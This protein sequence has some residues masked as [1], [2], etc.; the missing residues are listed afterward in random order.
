LWPLDL[1]YHRGGY[2]Y[3]MKLRTS[4][5]SSI[6][7]LILG[8]VKFGKAGPLRALTTAALGIIDCFRRLHLSG[9]CYKDINYGGPFFRP[10]TGDVLICDNDNVRPNR[11]RGMIFF[12][13]FAAPEVN[14]GEADCTTETDTHSLAVLLYYIFVRGNPFEGRREVETVVFEENAKLRTFGVEPIFVFDPARESNRPVPGIHD[15]V[16]ANWKRLPGY[17][18]DTFAQAFVA[19]VADPRKRPNDTQWLN[20]ISRMRDALCTCPHCRLEAV[21]PF[22]SVGANQDV[23]CPFCRKTAPAQPRIRFKSSELWL[24][25]GCQLFQHHL[26]VGQHSSNV[27]GQ[28]TRH[29]TK[30]DLA[31]IRNMTAQTWSFV[32]KDGAPK[33]VPPGKSAAVSPGRVINFGAA[34][35]TIAS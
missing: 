25:D 2:G 1:V 28:F 33:E 19:G 30:R 34:T 15:A 20:A 11:T 16:I 26:G 24:S 14:R 18:Q 9:L 8:R 4:D 29:E 35:G 32:D 23:P 27:I 6:E 12:P 10:D 17:V 5:Y 7:E 31:G 21:V 13:E 3:L 22:E